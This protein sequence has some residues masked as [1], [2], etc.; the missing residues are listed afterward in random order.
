MYFEKILKTVAEVSI[1]MRN[2]QLAACAIPIAAI[3]ALA[4]DGSEISKLGLFYGFD[5][6]VW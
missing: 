6:I 1:W 3:G 4:T 5:F 2:V